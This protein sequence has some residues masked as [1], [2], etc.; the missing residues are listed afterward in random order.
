M[1][2]AITT[3]RERQND[4]FRDKVFRCK[5]VFVLTGSFVSVFTYNPLVKY[6]FS[7]QTD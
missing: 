4:A 2:V 3:K 1:S 6:I 7:K 5:P